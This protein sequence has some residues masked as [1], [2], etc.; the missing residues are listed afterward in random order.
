[1][2]AIPPWH[3]WGTSKGL[4]CPAKP[5]MGTLLVQSE[6]MVRVSY[7]RPETW[8]FFFLARVI[9]GDLS[10]GGGGE[11]V[12]DFEVTFGVGLSQVTIPAF[13]HFVFN[14]APPVVQVT[15]FT[16]SVPGTVMDDTIVPIAAT[17]QILPQI[18]TLT[19]ENIQVVARAQ[20][21]GAAV[22]PDKVRVEAHTYWAP[23]AHIR[24]DWHGGPGVLEQFAGKEIGGS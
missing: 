2:S 5:L 11:L 7:K 12:V 17:P 3:R 18:N 4:L 22:A 6:Q 14:L 1:M 23:N 10:V 15:K 24:P 21:G 16:N 20:L 19:S 13:A 8:R 9:E